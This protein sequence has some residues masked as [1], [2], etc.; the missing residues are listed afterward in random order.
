MHFREILLETIYYLSSSSRIVLG[1]LIPI[2]ARNH[3]L[4]MRCGLWVSKQTEGD[5][6]HCTNCLRSRG[7][8]ERCENERKQWVPGS[9]QCSTHH[10]SLIIPIDCERF[11][12]VFPFRYYFCQPGTSSLTMPN[13]FHRLNLLVQKTFNLIINSH[14]KTQLAFPLLWL[15]L[16]SSL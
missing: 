7:S 4:R 2:L 6:L 3:R 14:E 5:L 9:P 1:I 12:H 11:A 8:C 15:Q 10:S 13:T 16:S